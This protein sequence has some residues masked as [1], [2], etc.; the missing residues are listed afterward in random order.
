MK[1]LTEKIVFFGLVTAW[2]LANR[3]TSRSPLDEIAT[4]DGVVRSPSALGM[5]SGSPA[6]ITAM[7]AFV[8]PR[9]IPI[10]RPIVF[11]Y[12]SIVPTSSCR[13]RCRCRR[14]GSGL[15]PSR[16]DLDHCRPQ[17]LVADEVTRCVLLDDGVRVA[18][19]F[20]NL[21]GIVEAWVERLANRLHAADA[22][23]LQDAPQLALDQ[24]EALDDAARLLIVAGGLNRPL[25][26]I[27]DRQNLLQEF[28]SR[29][30]PD[31]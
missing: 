29:L 23:L 31:P 16:S 5:T 28:A 26:V 25:E 13:V 17:H 12:L 27:D 20:L 7:T 10:V 22:R 11:R 8:V 4:I 1:R 24:D 19:A 6:S 2:R 15:A 18:D 30:F 3:P 21:N 9:S 14:S